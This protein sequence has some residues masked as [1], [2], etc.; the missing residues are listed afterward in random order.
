MKDY[1][2]I[3][4][5]ELISVSIIV[6]IIF[7]VC[8]I[9]FITIRKLDLEKYLYILISVFLITTFII[10][11]HH[12]FNI[13]LDLTHNSFE[14]YIGKCRFP[15][16]D[17]LILEDFD[18]KK[19]YAAISI[20]NTLDNITIIYSKHSRIVVSAEKQGGNSLTSD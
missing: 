2:D 7:I 19:L 3:L 12:I 14:T 4:I 20:P 5:E 11:G 13:S 9:G 1:R 8:V 16:R 6:I 15:A 17:T 10:G 18:N